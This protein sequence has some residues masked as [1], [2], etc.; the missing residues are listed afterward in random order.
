[1]DME[2][3]AGLDVSIYIFIF[4]YTFFKYSSIKN[5]ISFNILQNYVINN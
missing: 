5:K 3:N 2:M 1:M 4:F